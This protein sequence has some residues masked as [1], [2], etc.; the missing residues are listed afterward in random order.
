[1]YLQYQFAQ[2][3]YK[4]IEHVPEALCTPEERGDPEVRLNPKLSIAHVYGLIFMLCCGHSL[5][6]HYQ[7]ER[8]SF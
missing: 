3:Y 4:Y 6:K 5:P 7:R 2:I 1:M 8:H